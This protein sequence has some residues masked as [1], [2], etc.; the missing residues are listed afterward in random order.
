MGPELSGFLGVHGCCGGLED[1]LTCCPYAA[2]LLGDFQTVKFARN[3][4]ADDLP[5]WE[6]Q[7]QVRGCSSSR[8]EG[9]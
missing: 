1:S 5:Q 7:A 8:G 6:V 3:I 9:L 4:Q 2:D